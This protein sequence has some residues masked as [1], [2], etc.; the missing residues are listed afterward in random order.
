MGY[1]RLVAQSSLQPGLCT[2]YERVLRHGKEAEFIW[3]ELGD[4]VRGKYSDA[5][6][7]FPDAVALGY[8]SRWALFYGT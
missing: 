7:R 6:R 5:R 4:D 8:V 3:V 1:R 2:I